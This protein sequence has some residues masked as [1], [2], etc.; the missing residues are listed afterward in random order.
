M[1]SRFQMLYYAFVFSGTW[2]IP[3][4]QPL[5]G[6]GL[7]ELNSGF[8]RLGFRITQAKI[9]PISESDDNKLASHE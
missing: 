3:A 8:Q 4:V 1:N 5:V 2:I 6:S 7:L 9:S